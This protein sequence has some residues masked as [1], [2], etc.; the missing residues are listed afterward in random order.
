V[1]APPASAAAPITV[2]QLH[3]LFPFRLASSGRDKA[4]GRRGRQGHVT[5]TRTG[6]LCLPRPP[7]L[8]SSLAGSPPTSASPP[9]TKN[10][11]RALK[12]FQ[13]ALGLCGPRVTPGSREGQAGRAGFLH[14]AP[15]AGRSA[16]HGSRT[17]V[18]PTSTMTVPTS[19]VAQTK[20]D[21]AARR[22]AVAR[23]YG[24]TFSTA[25]NS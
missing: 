7:A 4:G 14:G 19:R 6:C 11:G 13:D 1:T 18:A 12:Q 2:S 23:N 20:K 24:S 15:R 10:G 5:T 22:I 9:L 25:T 17:A 16:R 8:F 3:R 21:S